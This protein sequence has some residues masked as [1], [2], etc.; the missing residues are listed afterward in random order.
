M[1]Y[2]HRKLESCA[3]RSILVHQHLKPRRSKRGYEHF[4]R[5]SQKPLG[6]LLT[7]NALPLAPTTETPAR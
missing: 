6:T 1:H 7:L 3:Q 5:H 2:H 4:S